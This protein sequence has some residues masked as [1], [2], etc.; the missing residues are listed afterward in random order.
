MNKKQATDLWAQL[1]NLLT[2]T[3]KV[4]QEIIATKAWKPLGYKTF[5]TAYEVEL[6]NITLAPELLPYVVYQMVEEGKTDLSIALNVKG[7][8]P[9]TVSSLRAQRA[10]GVDPSRAKVRSHTRGLPQ[11]PYMLRID[12]GSQKLKR[13]NKIAEDCGISREA[14]VIRWIN[15][16]IKGTK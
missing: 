9:Q 1:R 2:D 12:V 8:G 16:G 11:E 6:K 15:A 10:Q 7:I 13:I 4:L 5:A 14:L 3:E